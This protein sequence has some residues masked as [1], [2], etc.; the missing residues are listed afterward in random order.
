MSIFGWDL[1]PGCTTRDIDIAAGVYDVC[2]ICYESIDDC[3]CDECP[4]CA[5]VGDV[6]C[7]YTHGFVWSP[8]Q[9][10]A[11]KAGRVKLS[12]AEAQARADAEAEAR[13]WAD[14]QMLEDVYSRP[15][16]EDVS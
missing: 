5:T 13:A 7:C 4:T 9:Q 1:P 8:Q 15:F 10:T 2:E 3:M 14:E 12:E 16:P 11:Y 6:V